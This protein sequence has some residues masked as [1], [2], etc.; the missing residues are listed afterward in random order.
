MCLVL[1]KGYYGIVGNFAS[2]EFGR[3]INFYSPRTILL[4][5]YIKVLELSF[6]I[7]ILGI[8]FGYC[9]ACTLDTRCKLKAH[10]FYV[11][12]QEGGDS[13]KIVYL[14]SL[15]LSF[16]ARVP[17]FFISNFFGRITFFAEISAH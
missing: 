15:G 17:L 9:S 3:I 13:S 8:C 1:K 2:S 14:S 10:S 16:I 11:L 4:R 7:S 5:T 12:C 6:C